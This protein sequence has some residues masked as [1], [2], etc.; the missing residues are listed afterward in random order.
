[1]R[2]GSSVEVLTEGAEKLLLLCLWKYLNVYS[3]HLRRPESKLRI[4]AAGTKESMNP[5]VMSCKPLTG[6]SLKDI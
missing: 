5:I 6:S 3:Y 1:M 4:L 2:K